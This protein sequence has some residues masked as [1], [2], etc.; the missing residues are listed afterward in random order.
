MIEIIGPQDELEE[1]FMTIKQ[2]P[3]C[4]LKLS[5]NRFT[6]CF[7]CLWSNIKWSV[8]NNDNLRSVLENTK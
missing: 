8:I 5:C 6:N 4:P 1:L 7:D 3:R 2:S